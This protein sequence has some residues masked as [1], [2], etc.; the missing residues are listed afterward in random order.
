MPTDPAYVI[1][2]SG[3]TG[4]PKGVVVPGRALANFLLDMRDRLQVG[5]GS[6]VLAT[7]TFGFDI[8][9][10]E[11]LLPLI[12]GAEVDLVA[13]E[14]V[15]D[16]ALLAAAV[17]ATDPT[18]MQATP[19]LWQALTAEHTDVLAGRQMIAGGEA[20]SAGLANELGAVAGELINMYGPTETTIWSTAAV[21][22]GSADG[23]PP[24]GRPIA[25]TQVYVL[26]QG[27]QPCPVGVTGDLYIAGTGLAVGYLN[28]S[29]LTAVR[30]VADP[31]GPPGSRMYL[32][33]DLA[34]WRPD[35]QLEYL[36]RSDHQVKIRGHRI[37]LGEIEA[38]LAGHPDIAEIAVGVVRGGRGQDQLVA[39]PVPVQGRA[40]DDRGLRDFASGL[41]P[42]HMVPS[43][44]VVMDSLPQTPNG[45]LD[46]LALPTPDPRAGRPGRQPV[47]P[48][49][50]ILCGI[51][52][53][54]LNVPSV[55]LDDSFFALGGHSLLATRL[56][57]RVR[58]AL[59]RELSL[60]TVFEA[61]TVDQLS[62]RLT[63][64]ASATSGPRHVPDLAATPLAPAQRRLWFLDRMLGRSASYNIAWAVRLHGALDVDALRLALQDLTARHEPLR[65][66]FPEIDGEPV[67]VVLDDRGDLGVTDLSPSSPSS[68][69]S[70]D[71]VPEI[72]DASAVTE[73]LAAEASRGFDLDH[74]PPL[75]SRLFRLGPETWVLLL[76]VHHIAVDGWSEAPLATDLSAAYA[77][78]CDG[79]SPDW[80]PLPVSY[81]DYALWQ[82]EVLGDE[83]DPESLGRRQVEYW[84]GALAGLR[85]GTRPARRLPAPGRAERARRRPPTHRRR[86][87]ARRRRRPGARPRG[88]ACSWSSRRRSP[89]C[90]PGW[91]PGTDIP[92]G[93][94]V[95][96]RTDEAVEPMI[97]FFVNTL[98]LR[99]DLSGDP[100]FHDLLTRV[101]ETDLAAFAHADVPFERVV[102]ACSP[103]RSLSV[104][105]LFQVML[106][107][108]GQRIP[109]GELAGIPAEPESP[110]SPAP[111]GSISPCRSRSPSTRGRV[112]QGWTSP[113]MYNA[114]LF[115]PETVDVLAKRFAV[116]LG[117]AVRH[118]A[119]PASR[120]DILRSGEHDDVLAV[121]RDPRLPFRRVSPSCSPTTWATLRSTRPWS[122]TTSRS[123]TGSWTFALD[124]VARRLAAR[125]AGP[126][127]LVA[128]WM[129]RSVDLVTG[130]LAVLKT[131][132][133][134][135]ADRRRPSRAR[136]RE[137]VRDAMP[138]LVLG[139]RHDA[140]VTVT[141]TEELLADGGEETGNP[142]P[143]GAGRRA[144]L[145]D[146]HLRVDRAAEGRRGRRTA[147]SP[148]CW[149]T[150]FEGSSSVPG[151]GP[152]SSPPR[153]S[154]P[155]C[156]R[157]S[158]PCCP[159]RPW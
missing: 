152:S 34:R 144:R 71:A 111:H 94:P 124:L 11:L 59:G 24:I 110:S 3:S 5:V 87:H 18:L 13:R 76:T 8:C 60:R 156:P 31:L 154:T 105:P 66:V 72:A 32:T 138:L 86:D 54:V 96:G 88:D 95:A 157:S 127:E 16:P 91:G 114:D 149:P 7:T 6:R 153:A 41:L 78:R 12:S 104:H 73:A 20:L 30:F 10:L 25:N 90:C 14:T 28:R 98:V 44:V 83:N 65:T 26:D 113:S 106:A 57:G 129:P 155:R 126:G 19:T 50:E 69:S 101:R 116:L 133:G 49:Q 81:R 64:K 159:A 118:P 139:P 85:R 45:K 62:R 80:A 137:L 77:A 99:N 158:S 70:A 143:P 135:P 119:R 130:M 37:E 132:R 40:I 74:E 36:G 27:L 102:D 115:R 4:R 9:H 117:S 55:G 103:V 56:V 112:P 43:A 21:L 61:E 84:R 75:R 148:P 121:S 128:L 136:V 100:T 38:V 147:T 39:Y 52:A 97:G 125:G 123:P 120:L 63:R 29:G 58:S 46:R 134:L 1:Y 140:D 82:R 47:T 107:F 35:G 42:N 131:G 33:G 142:L 22:T 93:I 146:L 122:G 2:T 67:Q 89:S 151:P 23:P 145:R 150:R 51:F 17:A 48:V 92:I 108:Q 79:R 141:T 53:D 109:F 15:R 68:P